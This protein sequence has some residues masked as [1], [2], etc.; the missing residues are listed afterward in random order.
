MVGRGS[1]SQ[2]QGQGILFFKGEPSIGKDAW[3]QLQ[4][5]DRS[6]M[7]TGGRNLRVL[8][9]NS[10]ELNQKEL[11]KIAVAYQSEYWKVN[12]AI[13][14]SQFEEACT[15]LSKVDIRRQRKLGRKAAAAENK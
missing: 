1:R 11:D 3:E 13:F 9:L 15:T 8:F 6:L 10:K 14:E 4:A 12:P 5:K 2:G 7:D